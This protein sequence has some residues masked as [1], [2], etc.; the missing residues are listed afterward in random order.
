MLLVHD[1]TGAEDE[2]TPKARVPLPHYYRT[3]TSSASS[4]SSSSSGSQPLAIEHAPS[5][6]S[7]SVSIDK[8]SP[9]H[10][11]H[12]KQSRARLAPAAQR[13]LNEL[14]KHISLHFSTLDRGKMGPAPAQSSTGYLTRC[15]LA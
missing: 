14:V 10:R 2:E 8:R 9:R 3:A 7:K 6:T 4:A 12:A 5:S 1:D 15:F 11:A 13:Q